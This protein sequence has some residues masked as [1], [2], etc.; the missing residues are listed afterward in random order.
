MRPVARRGEWPRQTV[1]SAGARFRSGS[2]NVGKKTGANATRATDALVRAVGGLVNRAVDEMLLGDVR[3]TSAADGR[4][5]LTT[6]ERSESFADDIQRVIVLAVPVVRA[7]SR[8]ARVAKLP[9]VV[10][11][12]TAISVGIAVRTGVREIQVLSSLVAYR[13][14][15]ATGAPADPALVKRVAID[16][17]LHP[18][19]KIR[20]ADHKL[21]LVRLTRKWVLGGIFGR[22]TEKRANQAL[23][24]ADRLDPVAF[25]GE[26]ND[27]VASS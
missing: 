17:Y 8:G 27:R 3:V 15:Q 18:K 5:L 9:W 19:R 22:T 25:R 12:S 2:V 16:L 4:R 20:V 7:L 6:D 26:P 14:E 11:A 21:H 1:S 24:A 23:A 10:V 13:L